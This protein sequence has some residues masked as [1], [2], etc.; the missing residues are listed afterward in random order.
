MEALLNNE[1]CYLDTEDWK[2][3]I[4]SLILDE[5]PPSAPRSRLRIHIWRAVMPLP[6]L[7]KEVTE[8]VCRDD[9]DPRLAM[10]LTLRAFELR[11]VLKK[12]YV[13]PP[14]RHCRL[15][16]VRLEKIK[17]LH[18]SMP[19]HHVC[20]AKFILTNWLI[21]SLSPRTSLKFELEAQALSEKLQSLKREDYSIEEDA[22]CAD[23]ASAEVRPA[24]YDRSQLAEAIFDTAVEWT[25]ECMQASQGEEAGDGSSKA[26][27][28]LISKAAYERWC[29]MW[30]R[31]TS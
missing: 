17:I 30:G 7:C 9:T 29:H 19:S 20:L 3:V 16:N 6:R 25:S 31:K 10:E 26:G 21:V 1:A 5:V 8:L 2:P 28:S 14:V 24:L 27:R 22:R 11:T 23:T 12:W 4:E 15:M 18:P 13:D